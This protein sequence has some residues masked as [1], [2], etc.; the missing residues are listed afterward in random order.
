MTVPELLSVTR[1]LSHAL[2]RI[3]PGAPV[4]HVYRP[5]EYAEAVHRQFVER[6]GAGRK[7]HLLV[8]MN[9]GPWGMAQTGVPF[10]AVGKVRGWL[11]LEPSDIEPPCDQHPKRPVQGFQC[12]REEISGKRLWNW[13]EEHF[14][15]AT[16]F[17][18]DF[19]VT[20][21]CPLL[22][23]DEQGRNLTP[24]KL[25]AADRKAILPPCDSALASIVRLLEV[26]RVVAIGVWAEERA[27]AA[28]SGLSVDIGRIL[29]PSPA[30]P[31]ANRGWA[32][33]ATR[34]LEDLGIEIPSR[35]ARGSG[36]ATIARL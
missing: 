7:R 36:S 23:L 10:G 24:D 6:F 15:T 29:H 4:R 9:P 26:E 16:E 3:E 19:W 27:R 28:C 11:A 8:G 22:F 31:A 14:G 18:A 30:S 33:A 2:S 25:S 12:T 35:P 1:D 34:Q 20:N 13:A 17:F 21:Y 32:Q 5:L